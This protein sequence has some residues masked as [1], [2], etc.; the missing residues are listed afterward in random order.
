MV[1]CIFSVLILKKPTYIPEDDSFIMFV[2][3]F[4]DMKSELKLTQTSVFNHFHTLFS[5]L[6]PRL[7]LSY[8]SS[9]S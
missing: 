6:F 2:F 4:K 9:K 5:T 3:S 1:A 8:K 7:L